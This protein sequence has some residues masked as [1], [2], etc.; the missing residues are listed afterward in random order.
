MGDGLNEH[1]TPMPALLNRAE[2]RVGT[3]PVIRT[4]LYDVRRAPPAQRPL[5]AQRHEDGLE[6]AE[7]LEAKGHERGE[8]SSYAATQSRDLADRFASAWPSAA[9]SR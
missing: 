9:A 6:N 3:L 8:R 2:H 5:D 1:R 7:Q 4:D